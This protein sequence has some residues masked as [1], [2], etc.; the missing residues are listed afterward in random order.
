MYPVLH[1]N[2]YHEIHSKAEGAALGQDVIYGQVADL[3]VVASEMYSDPGAFPAVYRLA[4]MASHE[5]CVFRTYLAAIYESRTL[6]HGS[7][8]FDLALA[9]SVSLNDCVGQFD[10]CSDLVA[11]HRS[12]Y[13][14]LEFLRTLCPFN[15]ISEMKKQALLES[16]ARWPYIS[17]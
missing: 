10:V 12:K 8:M 7:S 15:W 5:H 11:V 4:P 14:P 2:P 9:S 6:R 16:P 13:R 1:T 3:E 17:P